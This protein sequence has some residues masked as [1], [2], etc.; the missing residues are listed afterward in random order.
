MASVQGEESDAYGLLVAFHRDAQGRTTLTDIPAF[1]VE[2]EK[3]KTKQ[4]TGASSRAVSC[5][6]NVTVTCNCKKE[7]REPL[8]YLMVVFILT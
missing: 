7:L 3:N 5:I 2:R 1:V 6:R 4:K 8:I